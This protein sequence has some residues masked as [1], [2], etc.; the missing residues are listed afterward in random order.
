[1]SYDEPPEWQGRGPH[2]RE[3]W[4]TSGTSPGVPRSHRAS[5][6]QIRVPARRDD[7]AEF[8][9]SREQWSPEMPTEEIR[10][11]P[12][13]AEM[14]VPADPPAVEHIILPIPRLDDPVERFDLWLRV[15]VHLLAIV[16]LIT[17]LW[18]LGM[19]IADKGVPLWVPRS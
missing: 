12:G 15:M 19:V 4:P 14:V 16:A 1:M 13:R 5:P 9:P 10:Q 7:T 18:C 3:G 8:R 6:N 17:A 2:S 11:S